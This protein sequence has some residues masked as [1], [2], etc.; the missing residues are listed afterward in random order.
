MS[1]LK[2]REKAIKLRK[3]GLSY[4]EISEKVPVAKSTLS[5]WLRSVGLAKKQRQRLTE[6]RLAAAL[7]G[8]TKRRNQR[9]VITKEIKEKARREI[10]KISKRELWLIG[11]ALYWAEG[12]KEKSKGSRLEFCNSDPEMIKLFLRWIKT[13]M[14]VSDE[15]IRLSI[16][17]HKNNE[18]RIKEVQKYWSQVTGFP[19]F[20]F[21]NIIWKKHNIKTNRKNVEKSYFGLLRITILKSTNL[22]RKVV[23]W[24]EGIYRKTL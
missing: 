22:N 17:I 14:K 15:S 10:R 18:E 3:E 8:A 23:G 9:L 5:L 12:A 4:R 11:T 13:I 20:Y 24:I 21:K 2:E 1:K 16:Y 7:R 6:K 19:I